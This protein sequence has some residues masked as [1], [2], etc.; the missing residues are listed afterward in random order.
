MQELMQNI[1]QSSIEGVY[2]MLIGMGIV[3]SFL[4]VLV[5]AIA[6]MSKGVAC[7]EKIWP[8]ATAK[9]KTTKKT[10]KKQTANDAEIAAAILMAKTMA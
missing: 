1:I 9:N 4:V 10:C 3:F 6:V 8:S 2:V 7:I 5:F